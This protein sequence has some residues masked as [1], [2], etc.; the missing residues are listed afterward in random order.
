MFAAAIQRERVDQL[1]AFSNWKAHI[2]EL[3]VKIKGERHYLWRAVDHQDL[4]VLGIA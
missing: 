4:P 1:R 3:F 2:D